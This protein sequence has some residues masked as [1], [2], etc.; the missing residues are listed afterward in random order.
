VTLLYNNVLDRAPDSGGLAGWVAS[1]NGGNSRENVVNGFSES[2]EYQGN[3]AVALR[4][5]MMTG[6]DQ[7]SD[8]IDGSQ[9]DDRMFGGRGADT[10]VFNAAE[11]GTDHV[12]GIESWDTLQMVGFGY[13]DA[14]AAQS[15]LAQ[16]GADV[17]FTDQSETITFH[18]ATLADLQAANW[19]VT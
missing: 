5:Y 18:H 6:V 16:S 8:R 1:L 13:A 2:A 14:A 4:T 3:T 19:I 11:G 17:V 15:H 10:F 9:G 12:Y 7:W